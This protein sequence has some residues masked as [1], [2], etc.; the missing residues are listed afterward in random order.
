MDTFH[1]FPHPAGKVPALEEVNL[2][3]ILAL[4]PILP[5]LWKTLLKP[6]SIQTPDGEILVGGCMKNGFFDTFD[7]FVSWG[8]T[9]VWSPGKSW[10]RHGFR[11]NDFSYCNHH[12]HSHPQFL[13]YS[14]V[15]ATSTSQGDLNLG[16]HYWVMS[17]SHP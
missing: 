16:I 2:M 14:T 3:A 15:E 13:L 17:H 5:S 9:V 6:L 7:D 8:F 4:L 11:F 10:I 1:R 12:Y